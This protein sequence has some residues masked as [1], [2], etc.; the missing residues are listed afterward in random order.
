MQRSAQALF[1]WGV[2]DHW[3]AAQVAD[4]SGLAVCGQKIRKLLSK[5]QKGMDQFNN[6]YV[7]YQ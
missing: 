6:P 3:K 7:V 5:L 2:A 4:D 1:E